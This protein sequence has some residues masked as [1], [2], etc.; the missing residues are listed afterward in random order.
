MS[1]KENNQN[2]E[3]SDENI[4]DIIKN[5]SRIKKFVSNKYTKIITG[6]G[7][8]IALTGILIYKYKK[9]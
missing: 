2:I 7:G 6:I 9:K 4:N 5:E 8:I 1:E 3:I